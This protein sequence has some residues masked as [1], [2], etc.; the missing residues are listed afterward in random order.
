VAA[1]KS[2]VGIFFLNSFKIYVFTVCIRNA[3]I[4]FKSKRM[5]WIY[6]TEIGNGPKQQFIFEIGFFERYSSKK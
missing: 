4:K 5:W 3:E 1:G 2:K 6:L